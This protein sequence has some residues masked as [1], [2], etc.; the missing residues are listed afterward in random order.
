[1]DPCNTHS[2]DNRS[3]P[4]RDLLSET[5]LPW[6][7]GSVFVISGPHEAMWPMGRMEPMGPI[8]PLGAQWVH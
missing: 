5:T 7:A 1:M 4:G 3:I 8:G 2:D 6:I